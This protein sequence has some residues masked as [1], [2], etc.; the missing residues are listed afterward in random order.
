MGSLAGL[1]WGKIGVGVGGSLL[2]NWLG[3]KS[4]QSAMQRTPEEM[5]ALAGGQQA[6]AG[7]GQQGANLTGAGMQNVSG[8]SNYWRT[9]LN[10][11]RPAMAQATAAPR[12]AITEQYRGAERGLERSG[13]RGGVGDLARAELSRDRAGKIAGLTTGVQPMAAE[14]LGGL[15]T[16]L[17]GQGTAALIGGGR[18][19]ADLLNAGA[20]NRMFGQQVG[21]Q[22]A[23]GIGGG[24][25]DLLSGGGGLGSAG[26]GIS[27]TQTS[28][29][30]AGGG[31]WYDF[32]TRWFRG[33]GGGQDDGS[34]TMRD[35]RDFFNYNRN[36]VPGSYPGGGSLGGGGFKGGPGGPR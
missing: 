17:T 27:S 3:N 28:G 24:I 35:W 36:G 10:G 18:T 30:G 14:Q 15:G 11:S 31:H 2:G 29:S 19:W 9:L 21:S 34:Q 1:P 33:G 23:S 8:A 22:T 13:V 16:T 20:N 12:A 26:G 4:A 5:Q 25:W 32:F 7:L 6:A